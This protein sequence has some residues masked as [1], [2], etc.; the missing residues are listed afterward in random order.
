[1]S[2]FLFD[3]LSPG[4]KKAL[5]WIA[6][7]WLFYTAFGFLILPLL[8]RAVAVTRL[9]KQLDRPVTIQKVRL[10][11]YT[12]SATLRGVW[13][14]DKDGEPLISWNEAYINFQLAS[15]FHRA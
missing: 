13:V 7:V 2:L 15:L 11:P 14:K 9:S 8:V 10:N 1:M 6:S 5:L 3:S 12:F 4:R